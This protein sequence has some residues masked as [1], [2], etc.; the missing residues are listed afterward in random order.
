ML[1]LVKWEG[2]EVRARGGRTAAETGKRP[3]KSHSS[4][5]LM[6]WRRSP[7]K[8]WVLFFSVRLLAFILLGGTFSS[9]PLHGEEFFIFPEM[10]P[11]ILL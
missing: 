1:Q 5:K 3:E 9:F 10:I 8:K 11:E 4:V 7:L 2:K 6:R